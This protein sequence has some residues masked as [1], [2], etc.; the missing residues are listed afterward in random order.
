MAAHLRL[1]TF[2]FCHASLDCSSVL[3]ADSSKFAP[4]SLPAYVCVCV[5]VCAYLCIMCVPACVYVCV[6]AR[7]CVCM[8]VCVCVCVCVEREK[9]CVFV[10][11]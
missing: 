7:V 6:C 2:T 5:Y 10:Y 9:K 8:C 4:P 3:E 11:V 1:K